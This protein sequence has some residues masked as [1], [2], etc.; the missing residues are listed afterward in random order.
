[1]SISKGFY[2]GTA[3]AATN[4]RQEETME[5]GRET[6]AR[7]RPYTESPRGQQIFHSKA[8]ER[9]IRVVHAYK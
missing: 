5:A 1:M 8:I 6:K 4:T 9:A 7:H 3:R 2:S